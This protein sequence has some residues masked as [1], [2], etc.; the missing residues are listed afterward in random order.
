MLEQCVSGESDEKEQEEQVLNE[1]ANNPHERITDKARRMLGPLPYGITAEN[2]IRAAKNQNAAQTGEQPREQ[3]KQEALPPREVTVTTTT[4][5]KSRRM[6]DEES[7]EMR[8]RE[9]YEEM[10][11]SKRKDR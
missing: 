7:R 4:Y 9:L 5:V 11:G 1:G 6:T 2:F 3:V 8:R 10:Y